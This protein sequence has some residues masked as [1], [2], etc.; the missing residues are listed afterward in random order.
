MGGK[1]IPAKK[2]NDAIFRMEV[3]GALIESYFVIFAH[4]SGNDKFT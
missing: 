4:S 2:K 3:P 1:E